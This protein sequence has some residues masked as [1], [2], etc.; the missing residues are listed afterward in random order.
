[1][2]GTYLSNQSPNRPTQPPTGH[3]PDP[4]SLARAVPIYASSSFVFR[5]H[6]HGAR[7]FALQEFGNLL[8]D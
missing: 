3:D 6:E 1:M 8:S 2:G 5:D 7:L 4:H